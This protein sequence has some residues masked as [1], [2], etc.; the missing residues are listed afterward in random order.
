MRPWIAMAA[1]Y[2]LA[3]QLLLTGIAAAY[4]TTLSIAYDPEALNF[5]SV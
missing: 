2:A 3:L 1:A 4:T 5:D